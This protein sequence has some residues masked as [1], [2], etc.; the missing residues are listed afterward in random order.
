MGDS[1]DQAP[2]AERG[3]DRVDGSNH[4]RDD[5]ERDVQR[6]PDEPGEHEQEQDE[7]DDD[8]AAPQAVAADL[9]LEC[10]VAGVNDTCGAAVSP[11]AEKNSFS[12]KP[13]GRATSTQGRLWMPVL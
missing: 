7:A 9:L 10:H 1:G 11:S 6:E 5:A 4:E 8:D 13:S 12:R 2:R 3:E